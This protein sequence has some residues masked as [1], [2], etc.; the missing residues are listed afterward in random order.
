[1]ASASD[2]RATWQAVDFRALTSDV[3][4]LEDPR[5]FMVQTR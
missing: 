2:W 1:M 5:A 3:A 4:L